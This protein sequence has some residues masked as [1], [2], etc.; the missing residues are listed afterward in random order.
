M[1][2]RPGHLILG[3]SFVLLT[4]CGQVILPTMTPPAE[5]R[6]MP[7]TTRTEFAT[8]TQSYTPTIAPTAT[9]SIEMSQTLCDSDEVSL[10]PMDPEASMPGGLVGFQAAYDLIIPIVSMNQEVTETQLHR[11]EEV[12]YDATGI[13]PN[14]DLLAFMIA[15]EEPALQ[16]TLV[17]AAMQERVVKVDLSVASFAEPGEVTSWG[18]GDARWVND[19][20]ILADLWDMS[21]PDGK[22]IRLAV[23]DT[24]TGVATVFP[25]GYAPEIAPLASAIISP[26]ME[27]ALYVSED[28]AMVLV[29]LGNGEVLWRQENSASIFMIHSAAWGWT[30]PAAWA[31]DGS[32]V[33]YTAHEELSSRLP[34]AWRNGVFLLDRNGQANRPITAFS[35]MGFEDFGATGLAWSPD[36]ERLAFLGWY[37]EEIDDTAPLFLFVYDSGQDILQCVTAVVGDDISSSRLVW[38]PDGMFVSYVTRSFDDQLRRLEGHLHIVDLQDGVTY[39][40][41]VDLGDLAGWSSEFIR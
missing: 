5:S 18:I 32:F 21:D 15:L 23:T 26:D 13:S 30:F 40:S 35:V 25:P 27:R 22:T 10:R 29:D 12:L 31:P 20:L 38:S 11:S 24:F 8:P 17:D 39:E 14:G 1:R 9:H 37:L 7:F 2:I 3:I 34:P 33:A 28:E 4:G 36:G 41:N 16:I 19:G 6:V